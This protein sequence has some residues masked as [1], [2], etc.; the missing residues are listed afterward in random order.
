MG[1]MAVRELLNST[2]AIGLKDI[3]LREGTWR[4][5]FHDSEQSEFFL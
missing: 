4:V 1:R 5:K 2:S 3:T